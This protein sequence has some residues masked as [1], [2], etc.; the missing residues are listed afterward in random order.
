[1]MKEFGLSSRMNSSENSLF[2]SEIAPRLWQGGTPQDEMIYNSSEFAT[3][4]ELHGFTA[5]VT[6]DSQSN[7]VGWAVSELRY[8]FEDGPVNREELPRILEVADW[9]YE[10]WQRGGKVLIRCAAGA[11]RSGLITA[12]VLMKDG[13][14]PKKAIELIRSKR[15]FALS[16][17]A[18]VTLIGEIGGVDL[19]S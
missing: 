6:L 5:V 4:S 18:F 7:P 2:Y 16:N 17:R 3:A 19:T 1:M 8:G 12:I 10:K 11:N 9:A 13:M 14:D 15:S